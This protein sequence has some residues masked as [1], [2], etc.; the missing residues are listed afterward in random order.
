M[1]SPVLLGKTQMCEHGLGAYG[2]NV[3]GSWSGTFG[4]SR[5]GLFSGNVTIEN[6][7][8][9]YLMG[10]AQFQALT[11]NTG[12]LIQGSTI[13]DG[14]AQVVWGLFCYSQARHW[15][16]SFCWRQGKLAAGQHSVNIGVWIASGS[17][18]F[19]SADGGNSLV[20]EVA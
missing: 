3:I 2:Q 7:N 1:A 11:N 18:V 13:I 9:A 4:V 6:P 15:Q 8:G 5:V 10:R 20:W 16:F 19:N 17:L 12:S 14:A